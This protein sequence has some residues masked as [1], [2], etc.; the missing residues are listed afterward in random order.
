MSTQFF[1]NALDFLDA[2]S[3]QDSTPSKQPRASPAQKMIRSKI[4]QH[5]SRQFLLRALFYFRETQSSRVSADE[6]TGSVPRK[7]GKR[8]RLKV[9][10]NPTLILVLFFPERFDLCLLFPRS[11]CRI[12]VVQILLV[13]K[14]QG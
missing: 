7:K 3:S 12:S 2:D 8:E 10:G 11:H 9:P 13:L 5:N 6:R 1:P 4:D 14:L